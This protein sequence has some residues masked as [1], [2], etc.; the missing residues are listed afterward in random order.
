[1]IR[2]VVVTGASIGLILLVAFVISRLLRTRTRGMSIRMQVFLALALIVGTFAFGLG[3]MVIDRIEARAV[4]LAVQ[5]AEDEAQSIAGIMQGEMELNG[6]SI[7]EMARRLGQESASGVDLRLAL[8]DASGTVIFPAN[9]MRPAQ[10]PGVVVVDAPLRV[11]GKHV[12]SVRVI[13]QTLVM[14]RLLEDFAPTVLV[15]S[16]V[17]GAAAALAAAWIGRAIAAPIEA[18][19]QFG[20]RVSLGERTHVP[21]V[22]SAREVARL[23][24]AIDSMRRQL[25][26][27][28]FV[29]TFAADLSHELKNPV[30]AIRASAEVLEE[31][32]LEEPVE[33]RRFVA[34]IREA[35][36]RIERLLEELL[37][38][39]RIEA[40]GA[41]DIEVTRLEDLVR[42]SGEV[43]GRRG[44]VELEVS[45]DTQVRGDPKWLTR[46]ITNLVDNA[47]LHG[48]P[49]T[50]AHV[51]IVGDGAHVRVSV[52]NEGCVAQHVRGQLFRRFVST[53][54]DKGGSGLGL[55]IVRA[56]AEAHGGAVKL[57][58]AGPPWVEFRLELPAARHTRGADGRQSYVPPA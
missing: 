39:A 9:G 3:L 47:L 54:V 11:A 19:S 37:S 52:R 33:A 31:S 43:S 53:R 45:G 35:A 7:L 30:A 6:V 29:E 20:E 2:L 8:L 48:D 23:V 55:A 26:G 4:S 15:I 41:S 24:R 5:A 1:M 58:S 40:R 50:R 14:L 51:S 13:K 36:Q 16:L 56:V 38:L 44:E 57:V 25:E 27:R 10:G 21:N 49:G 42:R 22:G 17:L 12:G 18:L 34:R 28:P 46:A 32:A